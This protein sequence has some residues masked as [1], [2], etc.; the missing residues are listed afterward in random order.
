MKNRV[1]CIITRFIDPHSIHH[2]T[3]FHLFV[4]KLFFY[5]FMCRT[6]TNL[7]INLARNFNDVVGL[8][9][10]QTDPNKATPTFQLCSITLHEQMLRPFVHHILSYNQFGEVSPG[11]FHLIYTQ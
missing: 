5:P 11:A 9:G 4:F 2:D 6:I 10:V 7:F 1:E 3:V 8:N